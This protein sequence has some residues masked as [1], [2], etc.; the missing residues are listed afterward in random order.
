MR[1]PSGGQGRYVRVDNEH[2]RPRVGSS[3]APQAEQMNACAAADDVRLRFWLLGL[4]VGGG[5]DMYI[6]T[7]MYIRAYLN[8][9]AVPTRVLSE[10]S[11]ARDTNATACKKH[12]FLRRVGNQRLVASL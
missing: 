4:G 6:H 8:I 3:A 5:E 12:P 11:T 2:W 9:H 10:N 1:D 7:Y